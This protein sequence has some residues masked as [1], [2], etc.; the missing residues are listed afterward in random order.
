MD[1]IEI[2]DLTR[3]DSLARR[4]AFTVL[5]NAG[6]GFDPEPEIDAWTLV[7]L[8]DNTDD[9]SVYRYTDEDGDTWH[10]LVGTDGTGSDDSRWAVRIGEAGL[11]VTR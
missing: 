8:T 10:V 9:V 1:T 7:R 11:D 4:T 5:N 6:K 3:L 2:S